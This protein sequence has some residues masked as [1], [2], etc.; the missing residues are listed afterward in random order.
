MGEVLATLFH[1]ALKSLDMRKGKLRVENKSYIRRTLCCE[2]SYLWGEIRKIRSG[3]PGK[4]RGL[5]RAWSKKIVHIFSYVLWR[6]STGKING[7]KK[8]RQSS[9]TQTCGP[10]VAQSPPPH[11]VKNSS[12]PGIGPMNILQREFYA[13]LFSKHFDWLNFFCTQSKFLKNSIA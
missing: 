8:E 12:K 10:T 11:L 1:L 7:Q 5:G 13:T 3:I 2:M 4:I 9:Q 6:L